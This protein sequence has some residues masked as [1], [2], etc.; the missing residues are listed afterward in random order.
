LATHNYL[1]AKDEH[2]AGEVLWLYWEPYN[3]DNMIQKSPKVVL[4]QANNGKQIW[5]KLVQPSSNIEMVLAGYASW[6]F[7]PMERP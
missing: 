1:S 4:P 3:I 7:S 5:E 2:T 6:N